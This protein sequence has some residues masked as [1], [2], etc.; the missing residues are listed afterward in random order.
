[1][2]VYIATNPLSAA[3]STSVST[4]SEGFTALTSQIPYIYIYI[5][6]K[7]KV[8]PRT[9]HEGP[10]GEQ[11]YSSTLSLN[12][13]LDGVGLSTPRPGRFTLGKNPVPIV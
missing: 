2:Y 10:E 9:G 4:S 13:A 1:M 5:K 11:R 7:A 3:V 12:M 8:H 6:I